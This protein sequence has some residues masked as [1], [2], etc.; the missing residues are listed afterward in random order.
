MGSK[1]NVQNDVGFRINRTQKLIHH[2]MDDLAKG[3]G[4]TDFAVLHGWI[5]GYIEH[6]ETDIYQKDLEKRFNIT[7]S[8]V[9]GILKSLEQEGLIKREGVVNDARLKKIVLTEE[10]RKTLNQLGNTI[11]ECEDELNSILSQ[12]D[13]EVFLRCLDA[14]DAYVGRKDD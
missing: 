7:K 4:I 8:H 13:K 10:G 9:T 14:I 6:H 1:R 11:D 3:K 5:L 2:Y 12:E